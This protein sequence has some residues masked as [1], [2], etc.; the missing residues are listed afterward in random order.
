MRSKPSDA[1][2]DGSKAR[3]YAHYCTTP[4][5]NSNISKCLIQTDF[6]KTVSVHYKKFRISQ[7]F[8]SQRLKN[9]WYRWCIVT[10]CKTLLPLSLFYCPIF[11]FGLSLNKCPFCKVSG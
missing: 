5:P 7:R 3:Y 6:H 10:F 4:S 8:F 11:H 2:S 1:Q 9:R